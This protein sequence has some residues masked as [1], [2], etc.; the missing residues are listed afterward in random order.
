MRVDTSTNRTLQHF[1]NGV[2]QPQSEK[3][4][5]NKQRNQHP[6]R[7]VH[8]VAHA[9]NI[10]HTSLLSISC[11]ILQIQMPLDLLVP[12]GDSEWNQNQQLKFDIR[13]PSNRLMQ[14]MVRVLGS[15][16]HKT[17]TKF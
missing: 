3:V 12:V 4:T 5:H 14:Q 8:D 16:S 13:R 6:Y 9:I 7:D 2:K 11:E 1:S 10:N 15:K 17:N